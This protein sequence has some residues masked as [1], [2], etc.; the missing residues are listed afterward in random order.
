[1]KR[2]VLT[3]ALLLGM[4][5]LC[6][7]QTTLKAELDKQKITA[8]ETVTYKLTIVSSEGQVPRPEFPD[9]KAFDVLSQVQS[10]NITFTGQ[11]MKTMLVYVL[12]LLPR[13]E[14]TLQ[15]PP[16]SLTAG[17]RKMLSDS[18]TLQVSPGSGRARKSHPSQ[19]PGRQM[20]DT[21]NSPRYEL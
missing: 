3:L 5:G 16:A 4:S 19:A 20:P 9:L 6:F 10:S 13:N 12:V 11:G 8:D 2:T 18:F 7:A 15:I 14:G 17:G 21:G 1:M